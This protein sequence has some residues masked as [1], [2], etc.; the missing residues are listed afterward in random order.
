MLYTSNTA[1][2][3]IALTLQE[4]G[5]CPKSALY[6]PFLGSNISLDKFH[7]FLEMLAE[8]GICRVAPSYVKF[9]PPPLDSRGDI[10][11]QGLT[12]SY[13]ELR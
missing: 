7:V 13:S 2:A 10:L 9:T 12:R 8:I 3:A 1:L 5:E 6:L 11:L 4:C